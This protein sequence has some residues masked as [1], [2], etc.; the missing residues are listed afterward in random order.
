[1]NKFFRAAVG[2][3][4]F[5]FVCF[6][7]MTPSSVW[8]QTGAVEVSSAVHHDVSPPLWSIP[9]RVPHLQPKDRHTHPLPLGPAGQ[10]Q[11][12]PVLQ[13]TPSLAINTVPGA[14][15]AGVG[16]GDYG[17]SPN[18]APPDT[19]AA[20]GL[21]QIVQWVNESFA[22]FSKTGTLLKGPTA[23][24]TLWTGFGGG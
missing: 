8:A 4:V 11:P 17:F 23:G 14:G 9:S 21:T 15:F 19:N 13:S 3:T 1:M 7:L 20:V 2:F 22:V 24:N 5:A 10:E 16:N 12:D 6:C 18:A